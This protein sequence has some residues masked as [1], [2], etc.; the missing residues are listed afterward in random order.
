MTA[1]LVYTDIVD[2]HRRREFEIGCIDYT[3]AF[4]YPQVRNEV[5]K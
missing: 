5:L 3:E 4:G 1:S 2:K